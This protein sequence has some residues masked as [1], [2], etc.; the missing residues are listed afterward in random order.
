MAPNQLMKLNFKLYRSKVEDIT[1]YNEY[2]YYDTTIKAT[3]L[4]AYYEV[5]TTKTQDQDADAIAVTS[6]RSWKDQLDDTNGKKCI[7]TKRLYKH[8]AAAK[9]E[10][11]AQQELEPTE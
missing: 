6:K 11:K 7:L 8:R 9:K 10:M 4:L 1:T 2:V 5:N 3:P